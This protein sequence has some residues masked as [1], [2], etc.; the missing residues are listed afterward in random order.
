MTSH[1]QM[2]EAGRCVWK[3]EEISSLL[4]FVLE[5]QGYAIL[6]DKRQKNAELY[7]GTEALMKERGYDKTWKQCRG[8]FKLLKKDYNNIYKVQAA[9]SGRHSLHSVITYNGSGASSSSSSSSSES[10]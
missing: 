5:Q 3:D 9:K 2:A 4:S 8:K 7:K 10:H 6:D 1:L